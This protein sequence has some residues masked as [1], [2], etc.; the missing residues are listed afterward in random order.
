MRASLEE[1]ASSAARPS[2][3]EPRVGYNG[4]GWSV[5]TPLG[6]FDTRDRTTWRRQMATGLVYL[7]HFHERTTSALRRHRLA[8]RLAR[9]SRT[10]RLS[11]DVGWAR[12]AAADRPRPRARCR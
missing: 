10:T 4:L 9:F 6:S 7:A 3:S 1:A 2:A 11:R 8:C 12:S 5:R